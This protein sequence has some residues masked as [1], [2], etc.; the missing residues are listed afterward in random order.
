MT[1]DQT[2]PDGPTA[3]VLEDLRTFIGYRV[4]E[5]FESVHKIVEHAV[6]YALGKYK[7]DDVQLEIRRIMAELLV[8]HRAEQSEWEGPTDCD[9]LDEAFAALN[10]QG[11]VARQNFSCCNNCGFTEI[12]DEVEEEEK[13]QPVDGYV[14]FHLQ[15]T[16]TAI[17][18]GRLMMAYGCV[19][20]D[21]VALARVATRIVAE[22]R[23]VGLNASWGGTAH[24]PIVV[25]GIVWRRQRKSVPILSRR[26]GQ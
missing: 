2:P 7:R 8:A 3:E 16:E 12:W 21:E 13:R 5:G 14:F 24:H 15:A 10:R 20:E 17:E 4:R 22:L 23:R 25:D 26:D 11:I 18:S 9:R 19:E 1:T 6:E